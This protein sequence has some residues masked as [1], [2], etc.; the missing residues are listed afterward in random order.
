MVCCC[1]SIVC[2]GL[3][4]VGLDAGFVVGLL[5]CVVCLWCFGVGV[6]CG[7]L[8]WLVVHVDLFGWWRCTFDVCAL[9]S[10]A[11]GCSGG[12]LCGVVRIALV[13]CWFDGFSFSVIAFIV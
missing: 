8:V 5:V 6:I 7:V 11:C 12:V 4:V 10:G 1:L 9:V 13:Y 3:C 2:A